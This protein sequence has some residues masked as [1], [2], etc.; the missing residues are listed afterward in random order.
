MDCQGTG[1]ST[2]HTMKIAPFS[3]DRRTQ[4][5]RLAER[6][7]ALI[8]ERSLQ[9]GE[10]VATK[11]ELRRWSGNAR[12]TVNEAVRILSDRGRVI[13]RPGP[14]GGVFVAKVNPL[15]TLGRTLLDVGEQAERI[16][17][18]IAVRDHL[19]TMVFEEAVRHR[20]ET[21]I[22]ELKV[23]M[24]AIRA[25]SDE[26]SDF[27]S[28]IWS[29]HARIAKITPNS[30]L[31]DLYLGLLDSLRSSVVDVAHPGGTRSVGYV[32]SRI[33]AHQA[34]V[35]AITSGDESQI[36]AA[37]AAHALGQYNDARDNVGLRP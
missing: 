26:P 4:G 18:L 30:V 32:K 3:E 25:S 21:D 10:L 2:V 33:D 34:L 36:P 7:D 27:L 16:E 23:E 37:L 13:A 1:L 12:A 35:D 28:Q 6:I 17:E 5:D 24:E 9:P 19:E 31:S 22:D 8:S 14:G 15:V 11:D 20:S 29:L